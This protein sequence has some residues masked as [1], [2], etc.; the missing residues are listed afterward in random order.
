MI[1][2]PDI[3]RRDM[4]QLLKQVDAQIDTVKQEAARIGVD[5]LEM[6]DTQGNY[7]MSPLLL[8]K[9]QAL[10]ALVQLNSSDKK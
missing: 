10:A 3:L 8:A 5:P 2:S 1:I 4:V 7:V 9:V 6:R